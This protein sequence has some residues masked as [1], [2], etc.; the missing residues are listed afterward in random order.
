MPTPP[1]TVNAPVTDEVEESV[2]EIAIALLVCDP[3]S[4]IDCRVLVFHINIAPVL[5]LTTVSVPAVI[6]VAAKTPIVAVVI[7]N[8]L[9]TYDEVVIYNSFTYNVPPIPTPPATVNAPV[10]VEVEDAVFAML[11]ALVVV[12]PLL[13]IDSSVLVFQTRIVPTLLLT[14]VS[15][16]AVSVCTPR[17]TIPKEVAVPVDIN[18]TMPIYVLPVAITDV[19]TLLLLS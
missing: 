4:V 9:S 13:D 7:N 16:P 1:A 12:E 8:E 6:E 19:T 17:L 10:I 15:V 18:P 5:V 11:I 3:R 2:L 14:T